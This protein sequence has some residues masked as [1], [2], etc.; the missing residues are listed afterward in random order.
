MRDKPLLGLVGTSIISFSFCEPRAHGP[1]ADEWK[2]LALRNRL[3]FSV[4]VLTILSGIL[5]C[6]IHTNAFEWV[7]CT[8]KGAPLIDWASGY[9]RWRKLDYEIDSNAPMRAK[10][11]NRVF[12]F[13]IY[14]IYSPK[15]IFSNGLTSIASNVDCQTW[16]RFRWMT[17]FQFIPWTISESR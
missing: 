9:F 15:F 7:R 6:C 11:Y 16:H 2:V 1:I 8:E 14:Q 4:S 5:N 3:S 10:R 17:Q 12:L 13:S